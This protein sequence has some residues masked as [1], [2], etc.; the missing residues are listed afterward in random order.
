MANSRNKLDKSIW[1]VQ[2]L[3][4]KHP[5]GYGAKVFFH[6]TSNLAY[7]GSQGI[8]DFLGISTKQQQS[9]Q[10]IVYKHMQEVREF[11]NEF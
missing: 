9:E 8:S 7:H 5:L 1:L 11:S 2:L 3:I 10:N 6:K 4:K